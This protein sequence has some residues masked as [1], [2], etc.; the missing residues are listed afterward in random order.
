M[1]HTKPADWVGDTTLHV[2]VDM[3]NMFAEDTD[4]QTPWMPRVLPRVRAIAEARPDRTLFTRFVP[5]RQAEEGQGTW[6][7][8]YRRWASMT[9]ERLDSR[10]VELMPALAA[11]IPPGEVIDKATYSPWIDTRLQDRLAERG[12]DTLIVTGGETDVCVLA[13]V[14][15]AVDRGLRVVVVTDALCSSSDRAHDAMLTL[16]HERYG[17]QVVTGTADEV[18]SVWK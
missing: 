7:E 14:L 10:M 16:Y 9:L 18:L 11:L 15:G 13:T 3:Q 17:T 5:L 1:P 12:A 2:C 6:R 8:Y 4:W